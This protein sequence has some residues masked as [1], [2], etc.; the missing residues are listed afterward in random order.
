[1]SLRNLI[2]NKCSFKYINGSFIKLEH[3]LNN[4]ALSPSDDPLIDWTHDF[5]Q[6]CVDKKIYFEYKSPQFLIKKNKISLFVQNDYPSMEPLFWSVENTKMTD[7]LD[8]NDV[9]KKSKVFEFPV[10]KLQFLKDRDPNALK[11]YINFI[12]SVSIIDFVNNKEYYI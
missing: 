2:L 9:I 12:P 8:P 7:V 4:D 11:N 5:L 1:M 3:A 6:N 10:R